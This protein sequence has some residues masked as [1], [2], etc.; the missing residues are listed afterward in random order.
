MEMEK[1]TVK[2][3]PMPAGRIILKSISE[4]RKLSLL[5]SDSSRLLFT[6]LIP[7]L[8][9][10]G[11]F[12]G[13]AEVINGRIFTRLKKTTEEVEKLLKDLE[14]VGLIKRYRVKEDVFLNVPDF[15]DKQPYL[16]PEREGKPKYPEPET[17]DLF[18]SKSAPSPDLIQ[19]NPAKEK[20]KE[21]EKEKVKEKEGALPPAPLTTKIIDTLEVIMEILRPIKAKGFKIHASYLT[22][23]I[24]EF[25]EIDHIEQIRKKMAWWNDHPLTKKSNVHLQ[26]LNWFTNA[27]KYEAQQKKERM[28]GQVQPGG[29]SKKAADNYYENLA[30]VYAPQIE[31]AEKAGDEKE[32]KKLKAEAQADM[33]IF[34]KALMKKEAWA[35]GWAN[36]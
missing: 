31:K 34:L 23:L 33:D 20:E 32:V 36:K 35:L 12:S 9:K 17:A 3:N 29:P 19:G 5:K 8:D 30:H 18:K 2:A 10:N 26:L 7:H 16:N 1:I 24:Q 4:S 15:K 22:S 21:K 6:W 11:C 25:P 13:D 14:G 27:R 28:V